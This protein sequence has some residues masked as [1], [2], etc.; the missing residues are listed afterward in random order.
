MFYYK[1]RN[2]TKVDDLI[3]YPN[4]KSLIEME[5][6]STNTYMYERKVWLIQDIYTVVNKW[7]R[8]SHYSKSYIR[9]TEDHYHKLEL[10][11]KRI[12]KRIKK[13]KK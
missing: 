6:I 1:K 5:G 8:F 11:N 10:I 7:W 12:W 3:S 2:T 9:L 13:Y 4:M